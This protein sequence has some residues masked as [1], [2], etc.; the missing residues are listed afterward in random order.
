MAKPIGRPQDLRRAVGGPN[1][2]YGAMAKLIGRPQDLRR[3]VDGPNHAYFQAPK[4]RFHTSLGQRPRKSG[5]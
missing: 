4:A 5:P 3:A 1:H 2:A